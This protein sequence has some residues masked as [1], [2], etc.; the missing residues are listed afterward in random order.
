[1]RHS[2]DHFCFNWGTI[3][4]ADGTAAKVIGKRTGD[5][6]SPSGMTKE[7]SK[8]I[9]DPRNA[10]NHGAPLAP[11]AKIASLALDGTHR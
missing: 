5:L 6:E 2:G 9:L 4:T 10:Q 8:K 3:D 1:M 11:V 7:T